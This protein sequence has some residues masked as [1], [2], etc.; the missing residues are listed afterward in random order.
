MR[1]GGTDESDRDAEKPRDGYR[2]RVLK[3]IDTAV[4]N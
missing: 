4:G 3:S 1:K 2:L